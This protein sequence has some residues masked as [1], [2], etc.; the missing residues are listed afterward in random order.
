MPTILAVHLADKH[1]SPNG[2]FMVCGS[3]PVLLGEKLAAPMEHVAKSAVMQAAVNLSVDKIKEDLVYEHTVMTAYV[4]DRLSQGRNIDLFKKS[5]HDQTY[6]DM[7]IDNDDIA[8]L[9]KLFA[10]GE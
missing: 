10:H 3:K 8:N 9:L 7:L 4:P 2:F 5:K 1:L 6:K